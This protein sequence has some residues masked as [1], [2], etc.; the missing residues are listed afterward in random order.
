MRCGSG[1]GRVSRALGTPAETD[2]LGVVLDWDSALWGVAV[3]RLDGGTMTAALA[4]R[5]VVA[6]GGHVQARSTIDGGLAGKERLD[7]LARVCEPGTRVLVHRKL[8]HL[9]G[10]N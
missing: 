8:A 4:A 6:E 7:V 3:A 2:A 9:A 10:K 5:A 1:W